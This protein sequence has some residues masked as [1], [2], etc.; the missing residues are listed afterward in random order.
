MLNIKYISNNTI[1]VILTKKDMDENNLS[2][3]KL[4]Q[5]NAETKEL[6]LNI[7]KNIIPDEKIDTARAKL[8]IEAFSR[9]NG[10]CIL[11]ISILSDKSPSIYF[12]FLCKSENPVNFIKLSHEIYNKYNHLINESS[13]YKYENTYFLKI[14]TYNKAENSLINISGEFSEILPYDKYN[15][16]FL[17][18]H[19]ESSIIYNAIETLSA[20][21]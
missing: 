6:I 9:K 5:N 20:F 11:Y 17:E 14:K 2:F 10:D 8:Y 19:S 18:E 16:A 12:V 21:N 15:L 7:V 1:K 4:N 13:L 3:E